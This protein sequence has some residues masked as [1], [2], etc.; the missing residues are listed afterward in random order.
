MN[1]KKYRPLFE[2]AL[3]A[4]VAYFAN[5][6]FFYFNAINTGFHTPIETIY[7]FF[8]SCSLT[9]LFILLKVKKKML[10]KLAMLFCF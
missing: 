3:V 9:I 4:L 1:L 6:L 8:L 7:E 10:N 2:I 5:K